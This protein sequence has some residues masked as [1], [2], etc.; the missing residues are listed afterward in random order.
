MKLLGQAISHHGHAQRRKHRTLGRGLAASLLFFAAGA[1]AQ[2]LSLSEAY[3][4]MLGRDAQYEILDIEQS[5][6]EEL[7]L[8]ARGERLPRVGLNIEYIETQQE[9]VNQDNTTFQ[10]GTSNYPTTTVTFSVRQPVYD[11]VRWKKMPLAQAEQALVS[12]QAVVARNELTNLLIDSYLDVARA[13]ISYDQSRV[14]VRARSQLASDLRLRVDAGTIEA[15]AFLRAQSDVFEARAQQ[16]EREFDRTTALFELQRFVGPDVSGVAYAGASVGIP[17]YNALVNSF[18]LERLREVSPAIQVA[19]AEIDIAARQEEIAKAAFLP[20]AQLTL[21]YTYEE[22]EGSLFGGGSTVQSTELGLQADWLIY[23]GGVRR[24]KLRE[25]RSR[26][27]IANLR[28]NQITELSE[29]RYEALT[30]GLK[31]ALASVQS[32]GQERAAAERRLAAAQEQQEAGRIGPEAGLEARLRRDTLALQGQIAR[33][34]VVQIQ[35]QILALFGALD[36]PTLS[37][38]F[39]GA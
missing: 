37:Q 4:R 33:L 32:V 15:D 19:K 16:T 26:V 8:Q 7:V 18:S 38:D 23:E 39:S 31:R 21:E 1:Q 25:A 20:T 28:L 6:A 29:R 27:E 22:T 9:I 17:N 5:I 14:M 2:T 36:V 24:S 34:R 30:E 12:A 35:A 3:Q 11:R 10:E 13:Q